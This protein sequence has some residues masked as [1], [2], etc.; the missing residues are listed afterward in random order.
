MNLENSS[1]SMY[2]VQFHEEGQSPYNYDMDKSNTYWF[3]SGNVLTI[4]FGDQIQTMKM[5]K[6]SFSCKEDNSRGFTDCINDYYERK[7]SCKLPWRFK[8]KNNIDICKGALKFSEYRNLSLSMLQQNIKNELVEQGC[9]VPRC[10]QRTWNVKYT[11]K[12]DREGDW[13]SFFYSLPHNTQVLVRKEVKLYTFTNFFAEV[14]GYLGLLLGESML[15]YL[16]IGT[17][18]MQIILKK[19]KTK[20]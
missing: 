20:F 4:E 19:I 9:L 11:I 13:S 17:H 7:M 16:I 2:Y 3:D 6:R 14:G 10:N 1:N 12:T 5:N 18:W 8:N 15:S